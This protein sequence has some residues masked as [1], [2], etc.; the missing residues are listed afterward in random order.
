MSIERKNMRVGMIGS[1][2]YEN[3]RKIKQMIFELLE[4]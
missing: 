3:K 2:T 1:R 4:D